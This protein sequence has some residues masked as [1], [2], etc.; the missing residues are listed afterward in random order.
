[1]M[2]NQSDTPST[3]LV[4]TPR[5]TNEQAAEYLTILVKGVLGFLPIGTLANEMFFE[6]RSREN[7]RR[8]V[9]HVEQTR[10]LTQAQIAEMRE[11]VDGYEEKLAERAA[12]VEAQGVTWNYTEQA[13]REPMLERQVMLQHAHSSIVD[14]R[15]SVAEH[16]RVQR[17]LEEIEPQDVITLFAVSRTYGN[18]YQGKQIRSEAELRFAFWESLA[19]AESLVA[20][21]CVRVLA[22]GGGFGGGTSNGLYVTA[23][24]RL[25]LRI[26]RT[27]VRPRSL[28]LEVPGRETIAGSR[29]A[30]EVQAVLDGYPGLY[31]MI[32]GHVARDPT[33]LSV[34]RYM[35]PTWSQEPNGPTLQP[36]PPRG[37]ARLDLYGMTPAA[38]EL[39]KA[40]APFHPVSDDVMSGRPRES[41]AVQASPVTGSDR[42]TGI[43]HGPHDVL[44]RV[45]DD[46]N[47]RS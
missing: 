22:E 1:M 31:E 16:A 28:H 34:A 23:F 38:A 9:Q 11:R 35:A 44:R 41:I 3:A 40:A 36:P 4:V 8:F 20:A 39:L 2:P 24:G 32:A 14:V 26:L 6:S 33:N 29:T 17:R 21:G 18:I 10:L 30:G 43:I 46:L 19:N 15:L 25:V 12:D 47:Q 37:A 7:F 5:T 13:M 27:Y 45:A 42:V